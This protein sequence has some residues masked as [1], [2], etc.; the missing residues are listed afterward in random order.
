MDLSFSTTSTS[1]TLTGLITD[2]N[3]YYEVCVVVA[4]ADFGQS[5]CSDSI[6]I[7]PY[8]IS[9]ATLSEFDQLKSQIVRFINHPSHF[10]CFLPQLTKLPYQRNIFSSRTFLNNLDTQFLK[11]IWS[12]P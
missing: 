11:N 5:E 7:K 8:D 10:F 4:S 1:Y 6:I 9:G 2:T 3:T 12:L